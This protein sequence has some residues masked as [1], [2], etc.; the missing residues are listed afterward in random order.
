M[1]VEQEKLNYELQQEQAAA[2]AAEGGLATSGIRQKLEERMAQQAENVSK[3][4]RMAFGNQTRTFGRAAE[5]VLGSSRLAGLNT[6]TVGGQPVFTPSMGVRGSIESNQTTAQ[7]TR[8]SQLAREEQL[9]KL[10]GLSD[11]DTASLTQLYG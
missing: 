10:S 5:D 2:Q 7:R 11:F 8:A 9:R 6:P 4:S 3:S 1:Q